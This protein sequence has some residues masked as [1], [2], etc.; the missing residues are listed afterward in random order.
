MKGHMF[1][2]SLGDGRC[3]SKRINNKRFGVCKD[4]IR[5]GSTEIVKTAPPMNPSQGSVPVLPLPGKRQ[6]QRQKCCRVPALPCCCQISAENSVG[7]GDLIPRVI[8]QQGTS[9]YAIQADFLNE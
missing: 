2:T 8:P 4:S 5:G 9:L 7:V 3:S 1:K 6:G